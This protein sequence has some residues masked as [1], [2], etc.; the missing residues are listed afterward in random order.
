MSTD[1]LTKERLIDLLRPVMTEPIETYASQKSDKALEAEAEVA[2]IEQLKEQLGADSPAVKALEEAI[3]T[4][5]FDPNDDRKARLR[6]AAVAVVAICNELKVPVEVKRPKP[7]PGTVASPAAA[8]AAAEKPK[9]RKR[10][11]PAE[12]ERLALLVRKALPPASTSDARCKTIEQISD[13][14][15]VSKDEV[16]SALSKLKREGDAESNGFRGPRGG[17]RKAPA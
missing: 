15:G 7:A 9:K 13:E 11:P 5:A 3:S 1:Q 4:L 8:P 10:T 16:R 14:T 17:W 2:K 6:D 12:I